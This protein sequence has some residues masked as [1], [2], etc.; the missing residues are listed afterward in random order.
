MMRET[1]IGTSTGSVLCVYFGFSTRQHGDIGIHHLS[2]PQSRV[3]AHLALCGL[4]SAVLHVAAYNH[5]SQ[6]TH[7]LA[8][9]GRDAALTVSS[10]IAWQNGT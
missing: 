7:T 10:M 5:T 6:Q 3:T 8:G 2:N 4:A 1:S 9:H